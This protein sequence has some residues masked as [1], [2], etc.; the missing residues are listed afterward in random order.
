MDT[1][2]HNNFEITPFESGLRYS[3]RGPGG[4]TDVM[5]Y[6][7]DQGFVVNHM[8]TDMPRFSNRNQIGQMNFIMIDCTLHGRMTIE[9]G[10]NHLSLSPGSVVI[11]YPVSVQSFMTVHTEGYESITIGIDLDR[12]GILP[13]GADAEPAGAVRR[14]VE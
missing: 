12:Y 3:I 10:G 8:V 9:Y 14:F 13:E 7:F 2:L 1:L 5:N 6:P 11:Y 4:S